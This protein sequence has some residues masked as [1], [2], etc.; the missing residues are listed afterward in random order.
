M[1]AIA[2][3]MSVPLFKAWLHDPTMR[4]GAPTFIL[5]CAA[6]ILQWQKSPISLRP[7]TLASIALSL[8]IL[9]EMQAL[10]Y[11]ALALLICQP[12]PHPLTRLGLT[13]AGLLWMPAWYWILRPYV[14]TTLSPLSLGLAAGLCLLSI[15]LRFY[16]SRHEFEE[17]PARF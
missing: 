14:G 9:G 8:G 16:P 13:A 4:L 10:I 17:K 12:I 5:W 15:A 1:A 11:L 3:A 6:V 7:S 2:L